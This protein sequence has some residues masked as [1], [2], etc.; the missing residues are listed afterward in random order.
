M[1]TAV[2]FV[3][4]G[5]LFSAGSDLLTGEVV[6]RRRL[7]LKDASGFVARLV[8]GT[9]ET[10]DGD[11]IRLLRAYWYD[12]AING[13]PT[14]DQVEIAELPK[15]KLRLGRVSGGGQK[16]VDGLII[17]DLITIARN[18]AADI[19]ILL[20]DDED[21]RESVVHAQTFGL[22]VV[23]AGFPTSP[24]QAQS[25]LL[26]READHVMYLDAEAMCEHLLVR[27][28]STQTLPGV[29]ATTAPAEENQA[30]PIE[31]VEASI[32]SVCRNLVDDPSFAAPAD[33]LDSWGAATRLSH[34]ADK[35]LVR[36][37]SELTG[38][39]PVPKSLLERRRARCIEL[40][41]LKAGLGEG[42]A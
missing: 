14:A 4:A 22:T 34:R 13:V 1:H 19:A 21:L 9:R 38:E 6:P 31:D 32:E 26:V 10:W 12:G 5:Y 20:S 35:L 42:P 7:E 39:F 16:G 25:Q 36:R 27:Q 15:M 3:D 8:A 28:D 24:R 23:L 2:V 41:T 11:P 40:A 37:L 18:R 30:P 29:E 17:L 33:L